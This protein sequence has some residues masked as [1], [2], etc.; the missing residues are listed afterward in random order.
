MVHNRTHKM[1]QLSTN[2]ITEII[3]SVLKLILMTLQ[4]VDKKVLCVLLFLD[5]ATSSA[6]KVAMSKKNVLA[7]N[8]NMQKISIKIGL[9]AVAGCSKLFCCSVFEY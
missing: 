9:D 5:I 3:R 2:K 8:Q 1:K 4:A 7:Q 6:L